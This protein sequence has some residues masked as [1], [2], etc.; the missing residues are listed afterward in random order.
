LAQ[1]LIALAADESALVDKTNL[2]ANWPPKNNWLFEYLLELVKFS[3]GNSNGFGYAKLALEVQELPGMPHANDPVYRINLP[4]WVLR[5][6]KLNMDRKIINGI[7]LVVSTHLARI[8]ATKAAK[9][10]DQL[11]VESTNNTLEAK[12]MT[13]R[14]FEPLVQLIELACGV[15]SMRNIK[16]CFAEAA[17]LKGAAGKT[18]V[19]VFR[20]TLL[21]WQSVSDAGRDHKKKELCGRALG[22]RY[23]WDSKSKKFIP[24]PG[25]K[26]LILALD[27]TW[28]Q[29][30]LDALVRAGWDEI[31]YP[32]EMDK[33]AKAIV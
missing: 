20:N 2:P 14:M 19:V 18:R 17:G 25:I 28:R 33:L 23:S 22:L 26:K 27:G 30:D 29:D 12:L 8:G 1:K 13:Y 9:L 15:A 10:I 31:F 24:R 6:G 7:S 32:D 4:D 11:K 5:R 21:N 3:T 16:A